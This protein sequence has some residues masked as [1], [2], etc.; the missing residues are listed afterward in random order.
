MEA[1]ALPF[2]R[3]DKPFFRPSISLAPQLPPLGRFAEAIKKAQPA[4]PERG[5]CGL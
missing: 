3:K 5:G 2:A 1:P 4:F